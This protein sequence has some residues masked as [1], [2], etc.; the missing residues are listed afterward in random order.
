MRLALSVITLAF[1]FA[2]IFCSAQNCPL[3]G[4]AYPA[5]TDVASRAFIEAKAKF[6]EALVSNTQI[7]R[8]TISFA[9]EIYSSRSTDADPIH[10]YYNTAA[11]QNASVNVGPNTL[12]RIHSISKLVTVYTMLSKLSYKYWHEPVTRYVPELANSQIQDV[13]S[14]VDW[15][16]VTLGSLA[17]QISGI[18]R[19]YALGDGSSILSSIPG[20]RTLN[21]FE[22]VRC[23]SPPLKPCTR[24]DAMQYVLQT[25]PLAQSY[26]TPNYSNMAFQL[27]AYAIENITRTPFP[28]LVTEV[29]LK[30]LN[31]TRTFVF[32]P[33]NDTDAVVYDGW[34]IDFGDAAPTAG[35]Y[36]SLADLTTLG[37]SILN[38]TLLPPLTTRKWLKPITHTSSLRFSIGSPWEI[39]RESVPAAVS[40]KTE[41]TR[42]VDVYTKQGGGDT[43]TSLLGISPDHDMGISILTSGPSSLGTFLAVRQLFMDIWLPAAEQ[44]ARDQ[45]VAN[46]AGNYTLALPDGSGSKVVNSSAEV[47]VHPDEPALHLA[48]LVSNGTDVMEFVRANTVQLPDGEE[49]PV[50]MW[51]YPMGLV[52]GSGGGSRIAFRGVVGL[53]GKSAA[54][55]CASWA[56][57]DRLRW[58]NYP[59]DLLV[60]ETGPDG[61]AK[62][63][64]VPVLGTTLQRVEQQM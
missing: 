40:P 31:L 38:S 5:A 16:E 7:N 21:D 35:Y 8:T 30:P 15:S 45:A 13:V 19:A 28:D 10:R 17:S 12:F 37:R 47:S 20:L 27:L 11:T 43:Y 4:P 48:R 25:W 63:L 64:E 42:I 24:A 18:S 58:G 55:N 39:L 49:G 57:G 52:A 36:S 61:R 3:L 32:H 59:A 54:E 51:L 34:D 46:F 50:R 33:G 2:S 53:E 6:D 23:G 26:R 44:A 29:I 1:G 41:T 14:D 9:I 22:V 56:E 62:A 60:F